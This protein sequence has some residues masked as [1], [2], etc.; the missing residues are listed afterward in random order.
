MSTSWRE[1]L[2]ELV[3]YYEHLEEENRKLA[4]ELR[5]LRSLNADAFGQG[6]SKGWGEGVVDGFN[7]ALQMAVSIIA[8]HAER[9]QGPVRRLLQDISIELERRKR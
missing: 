1:S 5:E 4:A 8:G 6:K 3:R 2:N 7:D 9:S